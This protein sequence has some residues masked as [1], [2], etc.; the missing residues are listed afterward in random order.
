MPAD[1]NPG[2]SNLPTFRKMVQNNQVQQIMDSLGYDTITIASG[3]V[4]TEARF[5][6]HYLSPSFRGINAFETLVLQY[7]PIGRYFVR[8]GFLLKNG[9]QFEPHRN[10]VL[11]SF[12]TLSETVPN[13]D[14]PKYVFAHILTPHPPFVFGPEG[15]STQPDYPYTLG[16]GTDYPGS[17]EEYIGGYRNQITYINKLV[18]EAVDEIL[19]QSQSPPIIIIQSDHGSGAYLQWNNAEANSCLME[20]G[21]NFVAV[22]APEAEALFY[23]TITPV[24]IFRLL[25]NDTFDMGFEPLED[26]TYFVRWDSLRNFT[27]ITAE[28]ESSNACLTGAFPAQ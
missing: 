1:E 14:S 12:D 7:T 8:P 11:F 28:I 27:D 17:R 21:A 26:K 20:R 13:M 25:F 2:A 3:Y 18:L 23:D 15:E 9:L 19:R 10:R 5:A 4:N 6:D 16:D 22:L 24:N